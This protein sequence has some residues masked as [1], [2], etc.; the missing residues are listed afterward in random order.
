MAVGGEPKSVGVKTHSNHQAYGF[1]LGGADL[2]P[3]DTGQCLGTC[4]VV[5][6]GGIPDIK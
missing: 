4:V 3:G 5:M 2:S 6:T 1:Q